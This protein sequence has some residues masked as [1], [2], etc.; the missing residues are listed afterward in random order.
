[1]TIEMTSDAGLMVR[2]NVGIVGGLS[3]TVSVNV[4]GKAWREIGQLV[5]DKAWNVPT[6]LCANVESTVKRISMDPDPLWS[7]LPTE[8]GSLA[9]IDVAIEVRNST[10]NLLQCVVAELL[11]LSP[12]VESEPNA[13]PA[14][15]G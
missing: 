12:A 3:E 2:N 1:M 15:G 10:D 13:V 4:R 8:G 5:Q 11:P 6:L 14:D 7:T 9:W